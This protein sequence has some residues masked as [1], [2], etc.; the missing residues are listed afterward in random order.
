ML[1]AVDDKNRNRKAAKG[2]DQ[3]FMQKLEV[4]R[5]GADKGQVIQ[6]LRLGCK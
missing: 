1:A 3:G 2:C 6:A 4:A 5:H